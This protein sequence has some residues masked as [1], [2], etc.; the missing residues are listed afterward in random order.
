M[1]Y[2]KHH[3]KHF[4]Q[5]YCDTWTPPTCLLCPELP[6]LL[7]G[8]AALWWWWIPSC[9]FQGAY[10]SHVLCACHHPVAFFILLPAYFYGPALSYM[11]LQLSESAKVFPSFLLPVLSLRSLPLPCGLPSFKTNRS[12]HC[13][14]WYTVRGPLYGSFG[15]A[16][17]QHLHLPRIS[18]SEDFA[19]LEINFSYH[20]TC[21]PL[22]DFLRLLH[23]RH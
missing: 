6:L 9:V 16:Y 17:S 10:A 21:R 20:Q 2:W 19:S 1:I 15:V 5:P 12:Q 8:H 13:I 18:V 11:H 22:F 23:F 14:Y 3:F 7:L 4:G